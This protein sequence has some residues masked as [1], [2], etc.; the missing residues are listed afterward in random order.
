VGI[1]MQLLLTVF[2]IIAL[3]LVIASSSSSNIS[4]K[5][6]SN[7]NTGINTTVGP[8]MSNILSLSIDDKSIFSSL[9]QTISA[10]EQEETE[11]VDEE[12]GKDPGVIIKAD[13]EEQQNKR[14]GNETKSSLG[15]QEDDTEKE[16]QKQDYKDE[17]EGKE[18]L[19][20]E[21]EKGASLDNKDDNSSGAA[22]APVTTE[23]QSNDTS[24]NNDTSS[25]VSEDRTENSSQNSIDSHSIERR[26]KPTANNSSAS[27]NESQR[28]NASKAQDDSFTLGC[29]P[30]ETKM[31]PGEEGSITCTIENETPKPI[32]LVLAC[33]GLQGTGIDCYINGG[34]HVERTLKERS[35]ANFTVLL[36]S[37]SSP[38]TLAG[39]YPF[40]ISVEECI[41]SD[42][43]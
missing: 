42:L 19:A 32:E 29:N 4:F 37:R 14:E 15:Q 39:S 35:L 16:Q 34:S 22:A 18:E 21:N 30:A 31:L 38:P 26:T 43:C 5:P 24:S 3:V 7:I 25:D 33:S 13:E 2:C 11:P 8:V 17:P 6:G 9:L 1:D 10:Q 23:E 28:V 20:Q 41:N 27:T 36:T 12:D 40:I